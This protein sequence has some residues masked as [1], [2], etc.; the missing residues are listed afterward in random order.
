[1]KIMIHSM[2]LSCSS[3]DESQ[4]GDVRRDHLKKALRNYNTRDAC[5]SRKTLPVY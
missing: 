1:M 4:D 5:A 3:D 2:I